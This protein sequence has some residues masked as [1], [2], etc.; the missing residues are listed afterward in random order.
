MSISGR[1]I[2]YLGTMCSGNVTG[3]DGLRAGPRW[4]RLFGSRRWRGTCSSG[5]QAWM[6]SLCH[7]IGVREASRRVVAAKHTSASF[8]HSLRV[9]MPQKLK[10]PLLL[11]SDLGARILEQILCF[12]SCGV[13][14]PFCCHSGHIPG[15]VHVGLFQLYLT[16]L[17]GHS[18]RHIEN[19]Q[20][21]SWCF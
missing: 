8:Y 16:S 10:T 15:Q 5:S 17:P 6:R 2:D 9:F 13:R 3:W 7:A 18:S 14:Q 20:E 21:M 12:L 19:L 4:R 11:S 1:Q